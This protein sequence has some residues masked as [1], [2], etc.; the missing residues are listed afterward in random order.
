MISFEAHR[1]DSE[2]Y[3]YHQSNVDLTFPPHLHPTL[4]FTYVYE[5]ALSLTLDG[6]RHRI[7]AGQ[8]ALILPNQLHAYAPEPH[9]RS[10][11]CIFSTSYVYSFCRQYAGKAAISPV[12]DFYDRE[13]V[14]AALQSP[15]P[16]LYLRKACF[17]TILSRFTESTRFADAPPRRADIVCGIVDYVDKNYSGDISL[18]SLAAHLKYD[19]NY[20]SGIFNRTFHCSFLHFVN[21]YRVNYARSLLT[22]TSRSVTEIATQ[23]GFGTVRS[24]NRNF[25]RF[26]GVSPKE[27]RAA[28]PQKPSVR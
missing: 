20:L 9:A 5:G 2:H 12:F 17:Y 10:Y 23:C 28:Q 15:S 14:C 7:G 25:L 19:Y 22:E 11:L 8:A 4:E 18:R 27:F 26:T 16:D 13:A 1:R 21:E 6:A 24:F 3:L